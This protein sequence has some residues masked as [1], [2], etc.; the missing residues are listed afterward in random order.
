MSMVLS[1]KQM[2]L[3]L[4]NH[5]KMSLS[6][7]ENELDVTRKTLRTMQDYF[8]KTYT[9]IF[10]IEER[11]AHLL[12]NIWDTKAFE[13]LIMHDLLE[14]E[15]FNS[16][17]KRQAYLLFQLAYADDF[18]SAEELAYDLQISRRTLSRDL[19]KIEHLLHQYQLALQAKRGVGIKI[20]GKEINIR[21][22]LLYEVL[23]FYDTLDQ[24]PISIS[25]FIGR[26]VEAQRIPKQIEHL[27]RKSAKL[28]ISRAHR[29][30]E[31]DTFDLFYNAFH[32]DDYVLGI[33]QAIEAHLNH[34][35]NAAERCFL[36]F[37]L[38]L[39]FASGDA[40]NDAFMR[41]TEHVLSEIKTEFN[42]SFN[43]EK[44]AVALNSHLTYMVNRSMMKYVEKDLILRKDLTKSSFAWL[45]TERFI[46]HFK[47]ELSLEIHEHEVQFLSSWFE[48]LIVRVNHRRI[49]KIA[50]ITKAGYSFCE[51][52]RQEVQQ[53]FNLQITVEFFK[54]NPYSNEAQLA[55]E[56]DLVFTDNW[57]SND[58]KP[59]NFFPLSMVTR[60]SPLDKKQMELSV[61]SKQIET[62]CHIFSV[63]FESKHETYER[64]L[65]RFTEMLIEQGILTKESG[66]R[67]LTKESSNSAVLESGLAFPHMTVPGL[68]R[69]TL[70]IVSNDRLNLEYKRQ[71]RVVD[72]IF[73]GVPEVIDEDQEGLL[74]QIFDRV[75]ALSEQATVK[76]RLGIH[77]LIMEK[78]E[79]ICQV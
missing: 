52:L 66:H 49:D 79:F 63:K 19:I 24:L 7:L 76:E 27:F 11:D 45:I 16:F 44:A 28:V 21:L 75:F 29:P 53:F 6:N 50:I 68:D 23:D 33:Q 64:H 65:A 67:L 35:L 42:L 60:G 38:S 57:L 26:I 1:Q 32:T 39:G 61:L 34:P 20:M 69:I 36:S 3:L 12:I 15:D 47:L 71:T 30:L 46:K 77:H 41:T 62:C 5:Q 43:S 9:H 56:Y 22:L 74:I 40:V 78:R 4:A 8:A 17:H 55:E 54:H 18:L 14:S 25:L 70:G 58:G 10:L 13:H 31:A 37:A 73:I 59:S 48:L 51:L 2:L 72:F